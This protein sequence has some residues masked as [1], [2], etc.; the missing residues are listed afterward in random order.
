MFTANFTQFANDVSP[1]VRTAG[2]RAD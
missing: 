1:D 2:P